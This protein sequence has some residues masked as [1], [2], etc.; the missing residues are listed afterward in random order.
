MSRRGPTGSGPRSGS[1]WSTCSRA[2]S[3]STS[4]TGAAGAPSTWWPGRACSSPKAPGIGRTSPG[5]RRCSSSRRHRRG[6]STGR[7][8]RARRSMR[9]GMADLPAS[10]EEVWERRGGVSRPDAD[11]AAL[12]EEAIELLDRGEARVAEVDRATDQ[13]VVH[14][15]LKKSILMLF[16]LRGMEPVELGPFEYADKLPL[17]HGFA[18]AGVRGLPGA[19]ARWGCLRGGG[20]VLVRSYV[21]IGAWVGAGS[22]VDT[23]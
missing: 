19:A 10:I 2:R 5:R 21:H 1:S 11:A 12:V 13:V 4:T 18:A 8:D 15:W 3:C 14:E 16:S 20:G 17:K 23:W 6:P 7:R 22:M 9:C